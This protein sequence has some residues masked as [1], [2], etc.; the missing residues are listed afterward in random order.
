MAETTGVVT[1][2]WGFDMSGRDLS[3]RPG[4][5]F[6]DYADG[7]YVKN[8]VIPPDQSRYGAFNVLRDL[9]EQRTHAILEQASAKTAPA[10]PVGKAGA[11]Y[12]AYMDARPLSRRKWTASARLRHR[13][14]SPG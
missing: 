6:F 2:P 5:N 9:S 13:R 7:T 11:F 14:I 4:D 12:K 10:D 1:G 8:L 3:V